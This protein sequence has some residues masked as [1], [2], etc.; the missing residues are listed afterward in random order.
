MLKCWSC[1]C[2]CERSKRINDKIRIRENLFNQL[3]DKLRNDSNN[4]RVNK[5]KTSSKKT[6][7]ILHFFMFQ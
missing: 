7:R 6:A 2:G 3:K 1:T 5:L 4:L